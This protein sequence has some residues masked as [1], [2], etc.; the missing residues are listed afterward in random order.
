MYIQLYCH[1]WRNMQEIYKASDQKPIE[2]KSNLLW[3][4]EATC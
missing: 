3:R 1:D 4:Q 2:S